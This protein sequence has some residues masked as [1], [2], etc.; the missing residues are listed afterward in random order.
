MRRLKFGILNLFLFYCSL[1]VGLFF[2]LPVSAHF[3]QT[4]GNISAVLHLDPDDDPIVARQA[5]LS[6]E[7]T[8]ASKHFS[9]QNCN[10]Q[11]T[12][13]QGG[14]QLLSS[15]LEPAQPGP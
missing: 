11:L 12:I 8:D 9:A 13:T 5:Y 14:N 7:V 3:L 1:A 4:D 2:Y 15:V 6:F 10:C